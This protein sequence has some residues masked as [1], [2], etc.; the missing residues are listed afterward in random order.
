VSTND[1]VHDPGVAGD[2]VERSVRLDEP[3]VVLRVEISDHLILGQHEPVEPR[4]A[5]ASHAEFSRSGRG[6]SGCWKI[7]KAHAICTQVVP[8][9][10]RGADDDVIVAEVEVE[11]AGTV[12]VW[13]VALLGSAS[14]RSW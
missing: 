10:D 9:F 1:D 14:P 4:Q 13:R 8:D 11:P 7:S 12:L 3:T 6:M 2:A 5:T